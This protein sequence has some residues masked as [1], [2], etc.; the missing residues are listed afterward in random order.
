MLSKDK[1]SKLGFTNIQSKT[2]SQ[3]SIVEFQNDPLTYL[4]NLDVLHFKFATFR[5]QLI[6]CNLKGVTWSIFGEQGED[7]FG[8]NENDGKIYFI[9]P[10][11]D[12]HP[13]LQICAE[14]LDDFSHIFNMFVSY[15][16]R[17]RASLKNFRTD[18]R[19]EAKRDFIS[20]ATGFLAEEALSTSYWAQ[21]CE[22][23][24]VGEVMVTGGMTELF[25]TDRVLRDGEDLLS[26]ASEGS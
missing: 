23:I 12:E 14:N 15:I 25:L 5:D 22:L 17:F 2:K 10:G 24:E 4:C 20:Y 8:I 18:Q 6:R 9:A 21:M 26:G 7:I 11:L 1:I 16:F 19:E 13:D 3:Y